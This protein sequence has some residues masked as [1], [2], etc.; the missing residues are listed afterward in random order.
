MKTFNESAKNKCNTSFD[1]V[2]HIL[3]L[4]TLVTWFCMFSGC[5]GGKQSDSTAP[6]EQ[7]EQHFPPHWPET[8]FVAAERLAAL[9]ADGL[10]KDSSTL[11]SLEQEWVDLFRW[12]PELA[13]DSEI[14]KA[15]FDRIDAINMKFGVTM[16]KMLEQGKTLKQ[17]KSEPG[18]LESI[19]LIQQICREE[20][21][22][23]QSLE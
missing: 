1:C 4:G 10:E 11:V 17:M 3:C 13:A 8:I 14:S 12:L 9:E 5:Y 22:R 6:Q 2:F 23:L 7:R 21:Q 19:A 15:D 20:L 16:E 18:I